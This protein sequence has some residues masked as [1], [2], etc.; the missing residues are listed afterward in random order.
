LTLLLIIGVL[1][2]LAEHAGALGLPAIVILVSWFLKY[3]FAL[4]DHVIEGHPKPPL[5]SSEMVNPLEQRPLWTI[6]LLVAVYFLTDALEPRLGR[7]SVVVLRLMVLAILPAMVAGMSV[8]GRFIDALNPVVVFGIISR[9]P[10]AY[11]RL[12]LGIGVIWTAP[13]LILHAS[14]E[15][16]E[17]LWRVETFIPGQALQAVG[18]RGVVTATQPGDCWLNSIDTMPTTRFSPSRRKCRLSCNARRRDGFLACA[19]A[20]VPYPARSHARRRRERPGAVSHRGRH[21]PQTH[22]GRFQRSRDNICAA[23]TPRS[24]AAGT[25]GARDSPRNVEAIVKTLLNAVPE[26]Q[27]PAL[28]AKTSSAT[29]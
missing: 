12:L 27:A 7:Q 4:P 6:L 16:L 3:G 21:D 2:T 28:A 14:S 8:T 9:I 24:R 17:A 29:P 1:L 11:A 25:S 20:F 15:S 23:R 22:H 13:V 26:K 18:V 10:I 19:G 5:L